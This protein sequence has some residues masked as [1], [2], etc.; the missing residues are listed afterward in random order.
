MS[1][2]RLEYEALRDSILA[3]SGQLTHGRAGPAR[4]TLHEPAEQRAS[5]ARLAQ[6]ER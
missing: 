6:P 5:W 4:R 1:R 3:V 2:K